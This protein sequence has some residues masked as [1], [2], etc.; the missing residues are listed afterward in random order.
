MGIGRTI[1]GAVAAAGVAR[2]LAPKQTEEVVEGAKRAVSRTMKRVKRE[3]AATR[4]AATRTAGRS[5]K[6]AAAKVKA[7]TG[8]KSA[9][10]MKT[11]AK[12]R[13]APTRATRKA[14]K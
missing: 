12:T 2:L 4:T 9:D 3:A 1:L 14:A 6:T 5:R 13:K 11:A 7:T 10:R 8:S